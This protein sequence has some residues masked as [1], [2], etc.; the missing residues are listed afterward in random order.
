MRIITR[1]E[2]MEMPAGTVFSYYQPCI[3]T[4]LHIKDSG[5]DEWSPDFLTSSLIG[6]IDCQN[7]DEFIA[8]C[9]QMEKGA[10]VE[11]DF[12][13]TGRE[14][15]FDDELKYAIY[16]P[17]DVQKLINRLQEITK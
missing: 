3:F 1:R 11:V 2:F 17:V 15:R 6:A 16:E 8:K 12:E 4:D 13:S 7:S 5:K 14:G 9:D 10:S